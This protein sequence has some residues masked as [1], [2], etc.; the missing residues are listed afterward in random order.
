MIP[1]YAAPGNVNQPPA[2]NRSLVTLQALDL[3]ASP[4][5][6]INDGVNETLGNNVDA[7]LDLDDNDQPDLPRPQGSPSA[8]AS[9]CPRPLDHPASL[10]A[11]RCLDLGE[12]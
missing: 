10:A 8:P 11:H 4:N 7:H 6:W 5:G 2:V 9:V 3:T 12:A 1:G